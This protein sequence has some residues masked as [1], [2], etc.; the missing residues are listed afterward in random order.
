VSSNN[1]FRSGFRFAESK[2]WKGA[3]ATSKVRPF[4]NHF[5]EGDVVLNDGCGVGIKLNADSAGVEYSVGVDIDLSNLRTA[6]H[7]LGNKAKKIDFVRADIYFLPFRTSSFS[8]ILCFDV[9]E[10]FTHP[11]KIVGRMSDVLCSEGECFI[12]IPNKWTLDEF[13]LMIVSKLRHS[14]DLWNV[15]HV[16]FFDFREIVELFSKEGFSYSVG[17]TK[18]SFASNILTATIL[19]VASVLLNFLFHNNYYKN[20]YYFGALRRFQLQTK[21]FYLNVGLLKYPSFN[22][23]T[24][25]FRYQ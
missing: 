3:T 15:R 10:H 7:F 23:L 19:N 14:K 22:Y 2:R 6:R 1:T 12:R 4:L 24:M 17:Y 25:V 20:R 11:E 13:L 18:G 16:S 5:N 8:K 21:I 9:L